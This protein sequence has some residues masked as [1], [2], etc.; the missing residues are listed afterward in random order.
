MKIT[1]AK[2]DKTLAERGLDF[3]SAPKVFAGPIFE[4]EDLRFDYGERRMVCVGRLEGR[5]VI[6]VYMDRE[7]ARQIISMRKANDREE[8]KYGS[9]LA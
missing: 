7:A 2:R 8:R 6:I 1:F 9:I 4:V 5:L 3:A